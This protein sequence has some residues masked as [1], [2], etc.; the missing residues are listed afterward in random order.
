MDF[1][2]CLPQDIVLGK[3]LPL[4]EVKD[5][6][7]LGSA[8]GT[9]KFQKVLDKYFTNYTIPRLLIST[10]LRQVVWMNKRWM[11]A[12]SIELDSDATTESLDLILD[13]QLCRGFNEFSVKTERFEELSL[14][15]V[16]LGIAD[17]SEHLQRKIGILILGMGQNIMPDE[18]VNVIIKRFQSTI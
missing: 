8:V 12:K 10:D 15:L 4:L 16:Q 1:I 9:K 14:Y 17:P 2:A 5:T 11:M 7:R 3:L 13:G 6:V 18:R